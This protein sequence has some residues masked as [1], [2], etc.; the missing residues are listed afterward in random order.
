MLVLT[1]V[2]GRMENGN[3]CGP[4]GTHTPAELSAGLRYQ[5]TRGLIVEWNASLRTGWGAEAAEIQ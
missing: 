5:H 3:Q 1:A 2:T 4:A